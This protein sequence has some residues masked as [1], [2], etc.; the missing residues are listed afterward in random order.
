M[1]EII[2]LVRQINEITKREISVV[3]AMSSLPEPERLR[4]WHEQFMPL[5]AEEHALRERLQIVGQG[6]HEESLH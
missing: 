5:A 3:L 4:F 1:S 6:A 2:G